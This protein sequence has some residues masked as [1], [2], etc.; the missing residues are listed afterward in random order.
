MFAKLASSTKCDW[1][2][3]I[4]ESVDYSDNSGFSEFETYGQWCMQ[5]YAGETLREYWF[6]LALSRGR[7]RDLDTLCS[8]YGD[9]YRS[10]SFHHYQKLK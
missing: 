8:E 4:L 9:R 10:V 2:K 1:W 7:M 3:V 5:E 6:N